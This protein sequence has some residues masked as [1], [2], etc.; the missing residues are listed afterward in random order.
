MNKEFI[1]SN[2]RKATVEQLVEA[3]TNNVVTFEELK[4]TGGFMS[5]KQEAANILLEKIREAEKAREAE[6]LRIKQKIEA[7][8][9]EEKRAWDD[10]NTSNTIK[11]YKY[12][13]DL[14]LDGEY[15]HD[16]T[17]KI[18]QLEKEVA[19]MK[20]A[21][22][23]DIKANPGEYDGIT[24]KNLICD[25]NLNKNDLVDNG[26]I[27]REGLEM[28]LDPPVSIEP[29]EDWNGLPPLA[30]NRTDIYFFGVPSSGKSC[31]LGGLLCF[32]R[33]KGHLEL[34]PDNINGFKYGNALITT[35]KYGYIA[36]RTSN[37]NYIKASLTNGSNEH[38]INIIE[39]P[40][41]KLKDFYDLG[42]IK[43]VGIV[44]SDDFLYNENK[45]LIFFIV[46][47]KQTINPSVTKNLADQAAHLEAALSLLKKHD[48]KSSP[49]ENTK[50][51]YIVLTKSD[52][53]PGGADNLEAAENFLKKEY[54][55]LW[56]NTENASKKYGFSTHVL[57]FSLG[58]F[59]L[60]E[61]FIYEEKYSEN[62]YKAIIRSTFIE[63]KDKGLSKLFKW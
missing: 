56:T 61:A 34:I 41:E 36:P 40:G 27:T 26:I 28:V 1:L 11:S 38:N 25:G 10:A 54:K 24:I 6:R 55:S 58:K 7:K 47:Y 37:V 9:Q 42:N 51:V 3:I 29:L 20:I 5:T 60:K 31:L 18:E 23:E 12:Y 48:G 50:S 32:A 43:G 33:Q 63:K 16:A 13:Q 8:K 14:Y 39:M 35:T 4:E 19:S 22:I 45:K 46:D 21:I 15:F 62:I 53:L 52:L 30:S 49:L 57:P 59:M 44:G 2:V 17:R